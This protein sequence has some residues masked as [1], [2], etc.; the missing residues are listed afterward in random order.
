MKKTYSTIKTMLAVIVVAAA[1]SLTSCGGNENS[2][3]SRSEIDSLRSQITTLTAG[4]ETIAKNLATF[5]TLDY[6]L[7]NISKT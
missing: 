4:D 6:T 1:I 7:Q 3:A 2:A 5:D